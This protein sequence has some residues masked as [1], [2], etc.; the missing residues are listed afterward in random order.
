MEMPDTQ[1]TSARDFFEFKK[2]IMEQMEEIRSEIKC[3]KKTI[4]ESDNNNFFK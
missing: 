3:I 1:Y 2:L 4:N